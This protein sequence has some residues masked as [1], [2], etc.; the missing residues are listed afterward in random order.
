MN[1]EVRSLNTA[2]E[3]NLWPPPAAAAEREERGEGTN[4]TCHRGLYVQ[5]WQ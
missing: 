4:A 1:I 3:E 2:L 5:Y